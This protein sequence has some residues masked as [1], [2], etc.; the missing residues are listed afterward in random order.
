MKKIFHLLWL[1]VFTAVSLQ[2]QVASLDGTFSSGSSST[3]TS[4]RTGT[5]TRMTISASNG[6]VGIN[7][8]IPT[9]HLDV[10]G[11]TRLRWVPVNNTLTQ[12]L[13]IDGV[14]NVNARHIFP[15]VTSS[16]HMGLGTNALA[17]STGFGNVALGVTALRVNTTGAGNTALG[18]EALFSNTDGNGNVGVGCQALYAQYGG[19]DF[20]TAVGYRAGFQNTVGRHITAIGYQALYSS[21]YGHNGNTAVG[22]NALYST[23]EGQG[24]VGL[25]NYALYSNTIGNDNIALGFWALYNN[26]AGNNNTAVGGGSLTNNTNGYDNTAVGNHSQS[27]TT[28]G[29]GNTALGKQALSVNQSGHNNTALGWGADVYYDNLQNSTAVGA[30]TTVYADNQ[31]R[32]GDTQVTSI[33]G[34]VSWSTLSDGRFKKDVKEDVPGLEFIHQ[35]RPVSYIIDSEAQDKLLGKPDSLKL[36]T[37]QANKADIRQS[38]FIAQEV[39]QVVKTAGYAF[40]GVDAPQEGQGHYSLRYADFVVPL[41]KAVQELSARVEE[42][43]KTIDELSAAS[44]L[45]TTKSNDVALLYQNAPN[46]FTTNTTITVALPD[47]IGRA[48]V[49]VYNL[50]GKQLKRID[51]TTRGDVKVLINAQEL[52]AGMYLYSLIADG[53]VVDTKRMVLTD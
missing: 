47:N 21:N 40:N 41:V 45:V 25:G 26:G 4:L 44:G 42:Q 8:T 17:L 50:E 27:A 11:Y 9:A 14:G 22:S 35:L 3:N 37:R 46:P 12:M 36:L 2:A 29:W 48:A 20:N 32:V 24:N 33:G 10:T 16:T 34:Q 15:F 39:E 18:H 28:T 49:V 6:Y 23:R 19:A 52:P 38:G 31:V 7:T 1:P 43:Q 5:T 51:V 13:M 53:K 30:W